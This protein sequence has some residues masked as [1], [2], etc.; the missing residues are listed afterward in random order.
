MDWGEKFMKVKHKQTFF[1]GVAILGFAAFISKILGAVYRIPYQNIAGDMGL[2]IYNKVYPLYSMVLIL[3]TAGFPVAISK[4]VAEHVADE[5]HEEAKRVL[6]VSIVLLSFSGFFLFLLLFF[7]ANVIAKLMGNSHLSLA[8]QSV[9]FAL[10]IVPVMA[11]IRGYFQGYQNM[12]PTA[13]SQMVEQVVRVA[14]ILVLAYYFMNHSRY[15]VHYAGA[16]AVFG[17]FT[18][19]VAGLFVLVVFWKKLKR[20]AVLEQNKKIDFNNHH[21]SIFLIM[22]NIF[23]Y[24]FPIALGSLIF[25]LFGVVDSFSISNLLQFVGVSLS[26]SE[27]SF[28]VYTRAQPLIQF[29]TFFAP[30]FSLA[31]VPAI[32]N[33]LL[34]NNHQKVSEYIRAANRFTILIG[35]PASVGLATLADSINIFFYKDTAGTISL[36][37]LAFAVVFSAMAIISTGVLNGLGRIFLPAKYL[38]FGVLVKLILNILLVI[39]L[40]IHGAAIATVIAYAFAAGLNGY[41]IRNEFEYGIDRK[42]IFKVVFSVLIM[43]AIVLIAKWGLLTFLQDIFNSKRMFMGMV[44]LIGILLGFISYFLTLLWT[45]AITK[46][47]LLTIPKYGIKL[48]RMI[49]AIRLTKFIKD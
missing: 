37:I 2:G 30:S 20:T 8:I 5:N 21:E 28:G 32:S 3:A 29:A 42:Y 34:Q 1:E 19:A 43:A 16:G 14:T 25:P 11:A 9:S 6:K 40:G 39:P 31:L 49:E 48:S 46:N 23:Y 12:A 44:T 45:G 7:G 4:I 47:E 15:G 27:S 24:S 38:L 36:A 33:S 41:A 10:L 35:L 26:D 13:Y 18:G 17:A 22:K